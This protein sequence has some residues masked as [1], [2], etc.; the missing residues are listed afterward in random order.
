MAR[1]LELGQPGIFLRNT[2]FVV[3]LGLSVGLLI[4]LI[5]LWP[6]WPGDMIVPFRLQLVAL[7]VAG[8]LISLCLARRALI[9][10]AAVVLMLHATPLALRL[11]QRPVLPA[12]SDA[13]RP[14]SLVFSNV[15][16]DNRD[17]GRVIAL[18]EGEDAD[19]FAA[20]E[21]SPAWIERL[22]ALSATYPYSYAP[23]AGVFGVALYARQPFTP[24]LYRLGRYN[25]SLLRADFGDYVVYVAH[26]MPPANA[27]LSEDNHQ[28]IAHLARRVAA[29]T[30]PVIVTGDLNAT[31]WS[32]S[33][34][35]LM[36]ARMSWPAGSGLRHTWPTGR[37]LLG[38]Q[39][40]HVL[41]KGLPAGRLTV[42]RHVG[43]DHLPVRADLV[44]PE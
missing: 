11:M 4:G 17:Y 32:G 5:S 44:L 37:A 20:A 18:A 12:A 31:L 38:I 34:E 39:I 43:S 22:K 6:H 14:L 10:F 36:R 33:M 41:T 16:A 8:L 3:G 9:G 40:D 26:P 29:E 35:P 28:Y 2:R 7:A 30:K 42:L 21:T 1:R 13:G 24:T 19:L 25:M 27:L 15:L 23:E